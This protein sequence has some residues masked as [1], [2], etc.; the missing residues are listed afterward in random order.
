M[1]S[2]PVKMTRP[3]PADNHNVLGVGKRRAAIVDRGEIR[4]KQ[5]LSTRP[6][7]GHQRLWWVRASDST[8]AHPRW[9]RPKAAPVTIPHRLAAPLLVTSL[10]LL[11]TTACS[12]PGTVSAAPVPDADDP[13]AALATEPAAATTAAPRG[14]NIR[15]GMAPP[16]DYTPPN[17]ATFTVATYNVAWLTDAHNNPY[18][19]SENEDN[20]TRTT[21]DRLEAVAD[22]IEALDADI[23]VLQEVESVPFAIEF[24][25]EHL[26]DAGYKYITGSDSPT[27]IQNVVV[28]SRFPL[29]V[30][31]TYTNVHT[32]IAGFPDENTGKPDAQSFTN[33]RLVAVDV[34]VDD[35]YTLTV[36]GV[37]FKAS[38]GDKNEAWRLGQ[39]DFLRGQMQRF[40][41]ERPDANIV[42]AG[43]FN[44]APDSPE[45]RRLAAPANGTPLLVDLATDPFD[46]ALR[47]HFSR[48]DA[49]AGNY[50]ASRRIDFVLPNTNLARE[51]VPGSLKTAAP[52]PMGDMYK[53]SDHLPVVATFAT[54]DK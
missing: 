30:Q 39:I 22:V 5:S 41:A 37:H 7:A 12:Q 44:C 29:G 4:V 28:M 40:L 49:E 13:F 20:T 53:A 26:E 52:L 23:L 18:I 36:F 54:T 31:Y 16:P 24:A 10:V 6:D 15:L 8:A 45:F 42:V 34:L 43:D 1:G 9:F 38:P 14:F 21:E 2:G 3:R 46:A 27:W 35:D 50:V 47:T 48:E 17:K 11:A 51:Q 19:E 32:P 25:N 33:N